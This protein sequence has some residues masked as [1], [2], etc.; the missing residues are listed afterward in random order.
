MY[1]LPKM[2]KWCIMSYIHNVT[3]VLNF[4]YISVNTIDL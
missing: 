4:Y 2:Q 1:V 3:D